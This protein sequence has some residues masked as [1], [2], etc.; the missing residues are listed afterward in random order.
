MPADAARL[1][2]ARVFEVGPRDGLQNERVLVPV[3]HKLE[4]VERLVAAGLHDIEIGSFV[5]PKWVPQMAD[6]EQL[7]RRIPRR[8]GVRY[9]ALVPNYKGYERAVRAGID[10]IGVVL[11]ASETHN[12]NNLNR[13]REQSLEQIARVARSAVD[14]G[15][16]WRGYISTAFGCPFEGAIAPEQVIE[17]ADRLRALDAAEISFGDTI[18]VATPRQ[19]AALCRRLI[20]RFGARRIAMHLHDTRGLGLVNAYAALECGV[21]IIDSSVAGLGGCPYAPGAAGNIGTEDLVNLLTGSGFDA[22]IEIERVVDTSRWL[23]DRVGVTPSSKYF[24]YASAR[25]SA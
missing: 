15:H 5:H 23:R 24:R 2:P 21:R 6:T 8:P 4:L 7:A 3:E 11:S 9:W 14:R 16:T 17:I 20:E 10:H 22:G 25:C 18:G 1:Q 19:V 13:S 12:R